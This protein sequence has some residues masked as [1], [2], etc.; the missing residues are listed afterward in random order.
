MIL[1]PLADIVITPI[2]LGTCAYAFR[3]FYLKQASF[4]FAHGHVDTVTSVLFLIPQ[5]TALLVLDF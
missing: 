2:N 5:L 4:A 1:I 3:E